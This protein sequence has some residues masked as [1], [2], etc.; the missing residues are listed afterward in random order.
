MSLKTKPKAAPKRSVAKRATAKQAATTSN[1]AEFSEL[2][3]QLAM[4]F[5]FKSVN[6]RKD[7]EAILKILPR[8]KT[9][10]RKS[11][12]AMAALSVPAPSHGREKPMVRD[13]RHLESSAAV[14]AGCPPSDLTAL[15]EMVLDQPN[16]WL[17]TPNPQFG[18]R[19]PRDLVGTAEESKIFDLLHAVDQGLF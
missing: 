2:L 3:D 19:E 15:L 12:E 9:A 14:T 7:V 8:F 18:G 17:A 4:Y 6:R 11:S 10:A 13:N 5:S 16:K 1:S